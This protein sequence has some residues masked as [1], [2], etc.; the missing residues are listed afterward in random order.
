MS[1]TVMTIPRPYIAANVLMIIANI[2]LAAGIVS[3]NTFCLVP[4][5]L[6]LISSLLFYFADDLI[7]RDKERERHAG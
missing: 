6:A 3:E 7:E 1:K 5:V 4:A 2:W